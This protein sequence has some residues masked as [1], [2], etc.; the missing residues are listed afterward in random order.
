MTSKPKI[1]ISAYACEPGLGSEI[2]VGWHWVLEMSRHFELWVLTRKSNQ[3]TIEPWIAEHPEYAGIHFLYF[4]L[5]QWAKWWKRGLSGVRTY[6][7]LWQW[8]ANGLVRHTMKEQGIQTFHHLTYGN[9]LW[10]VSLWGQKQRFVWGPIGGAETIPQDYSR[11]YGRKSRLI[12]WVRR[13]AVGCMRW[14]AG[15]RRRCRCASLILCKTEDMRATIPEKFRSK[16]ILFTDVAVEAQS[17]AEVSA[18]SHE[19]VEYLAVGRLDAWR[20]FDVMLEAFA[21]A[22][23]RNPQLHLTLLGQGGDGARLKSIIAREGLAEYVSMPGKVDMAEYQRHMAS[24]DVVVNSSLREGA[25]TVSFDSMAE[26]KPLLCVDTGGFTRYF[27]EKYAIV[28]PRG[29]R[30]ELV[31]RMA[32]A[33]LQLADAPTRERMG[34]AARAAGGRFTWAAKGEEI[35]DAFNKLL[36]HA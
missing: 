27:S 26:G 29:H 31:E 11:H 20:G 22:V 25:V 15:F 19:K 35:A 5:P 16:A 28:L 8:F 32:E 36:N 10:P 13:M 12:E 24:C 23:R 17:A 14:N 7:V 2:G 9:A 3:H 34:A 4:D 1:F 6:Y 21:Q 33:M 30:A 18:V